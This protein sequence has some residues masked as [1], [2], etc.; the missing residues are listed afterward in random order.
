[1]KIRDAKG[2]KDG[3][4]GY[5]RLF[6]NAELGQLM[7]KAQATVISNGSELERIIL[8]RTQNIPDLDE[9]VYRTKNGVQP[10]GVYVCRKAVLK[11]SRL[12]VPKHEPDLLVFIV[13]ENPVCKV[14][15]LKDGDMFDTKKSRGER[16][17]LEEFVSQFGGN[18]N[19]NTEYYVCCFNQEDKNIIKTGFK[20]VFDTDHILTGK[21]LCRVLRIDYDDIIRNRKADAQDNFRYFISQMLE[22][23]EVIY[24]IGRQLKEKK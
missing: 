5:I 4:S 22:I 2:R 13:Q 17:H 15:E 21:E 18:I 14:V 24:E 23:P 16:E 11:K 12:T 7:S 3:N 10:Y 19:F 20:E 9:F 1:M 8:E 6:D